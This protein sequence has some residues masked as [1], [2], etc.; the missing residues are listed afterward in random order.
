MAEFSNVSRRWI[1]SLLTGV[2]VAPVVTWS[3]APSPGRAEKTVLVNGWIL[4]AD[5]VEKAAVHAA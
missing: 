1:F 5:D 2:L 3:S 4:R